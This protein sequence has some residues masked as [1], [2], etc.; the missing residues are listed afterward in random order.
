MRP[1]E[2]ADLDGEPIGADYGPQFSIV[3]ERALGARDACR[4]C[5]RISAAESLADPLVTVPPWLK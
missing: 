3:V 4:R 1:T 5:D 2:S